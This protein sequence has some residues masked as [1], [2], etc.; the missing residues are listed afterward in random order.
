MVDLT[1]KSSQ[2]SAQFSVSV[3]LQ[4]VAT[5]WRVLMRKPQIPAAICGYA[6]A[7]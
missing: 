6:M 2:E 1:A 4:L 3:L 7:K 5:E